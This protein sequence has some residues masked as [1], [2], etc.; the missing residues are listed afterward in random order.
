VSSANQLK[1]RQ[2]WL[3]KSRL[4]FFSSKIFI[5]GKLGGRAPLVATQLPKPFILIFGVLH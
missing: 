2:A 5:K 4:Q 3:T 1:N